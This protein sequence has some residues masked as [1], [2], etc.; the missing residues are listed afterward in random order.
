MS[1]FVHNY[2]Y[3]LLFMLLELDNAIYIIYNIAYAHPC[4]YARAYRQT[5]TDACVKIH[6]IYVYLECIGYNYNMIF[7]M[8]CEHYRAE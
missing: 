3:R 8:L 2:N 7:C 6:V 4:T 5:H 1:L